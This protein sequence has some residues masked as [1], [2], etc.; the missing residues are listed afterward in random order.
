[1]SRNK[2]DLRGSRGRVPCRLSLGLPTAKGEADDE[3]AAGEE[4]PEPVERPR[5]LFIFRFPAHSPFLSPLTVC[6]GVR[7]LLYEAIRKHGKVE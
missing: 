7:S 4:H 6:G 1:M 2:L 3:V 5:V